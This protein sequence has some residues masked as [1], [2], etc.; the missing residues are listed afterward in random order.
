ML[1]ES[2][3]LSHGSRTPPIGSGNVQKVK[4]RLEKTKKIQLPNLLIRYDTK[5]MSKLKKNFTQA[6]LKNVSLRHKTKLYYNLEDMN[7]VKQKLAMDNNVKN[8][9]CGISA[10][11]PTKRWN[12][13]NYIDLFKNLSEKFKCK[14]FLAG[15]PKDQE[16]INKI[17]S[18]S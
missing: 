7:N 12:I 17:K 11:G 5:N 1:Q 2:P 9:I 16:L 3:T 10:S 13:T 18:L 8:I 15:G 4:A 6:C 14:F